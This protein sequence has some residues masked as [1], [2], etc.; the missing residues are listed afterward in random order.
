MSI[1]DE[2]AIKAFKSIFE[3]DKCGIKEECTIYG[4]DLNPLS[5]IDCEGEVYLDAFRTG[6]NAAIEEINNNA[7]SK[8]MAATNYAKE[9]M[10]EVFDLVVKD[11]NEKINDVLKGK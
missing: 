10:T 9:K 7:E 8:I 2:K 6:W 4:G 1:R 11:Y 3:C 5:S